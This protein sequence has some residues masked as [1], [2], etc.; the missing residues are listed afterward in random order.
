MGIEIGIVV[1]SSERERRGRV[2]QQQAGLL[3]KTSHHL[4]VPF[5]R[6]HEHVHW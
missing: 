6:I 4:N 1:D 5:G 3:Q 2:V